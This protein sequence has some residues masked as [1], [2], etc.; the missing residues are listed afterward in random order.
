MLQSDTTTV[1]NNE[2][3]VAGASHTTTGYPTT[4]AGDGFVHLVTKPDSGVANT[5]YYVIDFGATGVEFDFVALMGCNFAT[6]LPSA[7]VTFQLDSTDLGGAGPT[8]TFASTETVANFGQP[9]TNDR[10]CDWSCYHTGAVPLRYSNVRYA[11]LV[12]PNDAAAF[13]PEI[14]ELIVGRRYQLKNRPLNPFSKDGLSRVSE[15]AKTTGGVIQKVV[16]SKGAYA[17]SGA[18][19]VSETTHVT[20]MRNWFNAHSGVFLWCWAPSTAGNSFHLMAQDNDVLALTNEEWNEQTFNIDAL[21]QG[22][23]RFYLVNE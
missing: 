14:G 11:R 3:T 21:E 22:P 2:G 6:W 16:L 13:Q 9:T 23:E 15:T 10:L 20:N 7:D 12:M 1:W 18:F 19:K 17:M 5:M 4:R 8:G